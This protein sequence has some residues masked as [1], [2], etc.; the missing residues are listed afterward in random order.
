VSLLQRDKTLYND[1]CPHVKLK[2]E[3]TLEN[4]SWHQPQTPSADLYRHGLRTSREFVG[5]HEVRTAWTKRYT[6][7]EYLKL[8]Q[9]FSNHRAMPE[10]NKSRFFEAIGRVSTQMGGE[11]IRH[12]ETLA[13][14]AKK[15]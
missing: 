10:P 7:E 11:V 13:L 5:V 12:Y 8:L 6:G 15:G 3:A 1:L 14:L 4:V 9:T 2:L